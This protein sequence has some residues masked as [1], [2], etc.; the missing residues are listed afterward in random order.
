MQSIALSAE[1]TSLVSM[2]P[3]ELKKALISAGHEV[4][5]TLGQEIVLADRAREN[6]VLDS[7]V[8]VRV[9]DDGGFEVRVILGMR[10]SLH[11]TDAES[12]LYDRIRELAKDLSSD[13]F[14]EAHAAPRS[15]P[16]PA[17]AAKTLDTFCE[18]IFT[19]RVDS[20]DAPAIR[21]ALLT[22]KT[23]ESRH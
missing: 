9:H 4:F 12:V 13:G 20:L 5:R 7:G 3:Q 1:A 21:L 11:P 16:D 15:I 19:K 17:D 14:I 22:A 18:V 8:R 23:A 10:K 2:T 6:L